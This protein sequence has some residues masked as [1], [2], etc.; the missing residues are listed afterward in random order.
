MNMDNIYSVLPG[1]EG[2]DEEEDAS[3]QETPPQSTRQGLPGE[4][5][6][7]ARALAAARAA[8]ARRTRQ[9]QGGVSAQEESDG[10]AAARTRSD[11]DPNASGHR[12]ED[13]CGPVRSA[14][15]DPKRI[16]IFISV[17]RES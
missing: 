16:K 1:A 7:N 5:S 11:A 6:P 4:R 9:R 10:N 14:D 13:S 8:A 2:F 15:R 3:P 12:G 17:L